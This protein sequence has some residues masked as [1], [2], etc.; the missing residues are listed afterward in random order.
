[1]PT[2]M[3]ITPGR[4]NRLEGHERTHGQRAVTVAGARRAGAELILYSHRLKSKFSDAATACPQHSCQARLCEG[5]A[6][7]RGTFV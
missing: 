1:M 7:D 3:A 2:S 6:R 5:A 4:C